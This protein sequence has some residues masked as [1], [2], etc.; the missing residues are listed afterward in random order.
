[1][2]LSRGSSSL[3]LGNRKTDD[4]RRINVSSS[5]PVSTPQSR[6][7]LIGSAR[8]LESS[9]TTDDRF[10]F[11][12]FLKKGITEPTFSPF[13]QFRRIRDIQKSEPEVDSKTGRTKGPGTRFLDALGYEELPAT[14]ARQAFRRTSEQGGKDAVTLRDLPGEIKKGFKEDESF[15]RVF[16]EELAGGKTFDELS[17]GQ[18]I[19]IPTLGLAADI[20]L[21]PT[22]YIPFVGL[23]KAGAKAAKFGVGITRGGVDAA[24]GAERVSKARKA[25][26]VDDILESKL[27]AKDIRGKITPSAPKLDKEG[28]IE[29][30]R[31]GLRQKT[32]EADVIGARAGESLIESKLTPE[33]RTTLE[34]LNEGKQFIDSV[35]DA[36]VR[37]ITENLDL[38][39]YTNARNISRLQPSK[40]DDLLDFGKATIDEVPKTLKADVQSQVKLLAKELDVAEEIAE[41]K[42]VPLAFQR[43]LDAKP[44]A[45][46]KRA[47]AASKG[48]APSIVDGAKLS[49]ANLKEVRKIAGS[50]KGVKKV[51]NTDDDITKKFSQAA[52]DIARKFDIPEDVLERRLKVLLSENTLRQ[53]AKTVDDVAVNV[54]NA[55]NDDQVRLLV[56]SETVDQRIADILA[57]L[58][59]TAKKKGNAVDV[60]PL[61]VARRLFNEPELGAGKKRSF[62]DAVLG[63]GDD[64]VAQ[65]SRVSEPGLLAAGKE[66]DVLKF[67]K[68]IPEEQKAALGGVA[69]IE[70]RVAKGM[71]QSKRLE[72]QLKFFDYVSGTP[73]AQVEKPSAGWVQVKDKAFGPLDKMWVPKPLKHFFDAQS[74]II[75]P[76][77]GK[78]GP[79]IKSIDWLTSRFREGKVVLSPASV[80]R[81]SMSNQLLNFLV[82]PASLLYAPKAIKGTAKGKSA[83]RA[84]RKAREAGDAGA[85]KLANKEFLE[86][87]DDWMQ[88]QRMGGA[89]TSYAR[90]EVMDISNPAKNLDETMKIEQA[91][92]NTMGKIWRDKV[93]EPAASVRAFSEDMGKFQMFLY[94]KSR[95][96]TA[97]QAFNKAQKAT[98]DYGDLTPFEKAYMRRFFAFY[99]FT[100]KSVPLVLSTALNKPQRIN[101]FGDAINEVEGLTENDPNLNEENLPLWARDLVRLPIKDVHGSYR[102]LDLGYI[103]PWGT[104]FESNVNELG[105]PVFG[106][107]N[108]VI[109]E[110]IEQSQNL[111][112][113]TGQPIVG[114]ADAEFPVDA[115]LKRAGHALETFEPRPATIARQK[116][117]PALLGAEKS[118]TGQDLSLTDTLLGDIGGIKLR[119]FEQGKGKRSASFKKSSVLSE[120]NKQIYFAENDGTLTDGQ[121]ERKVQKLEKLKKQVNQGKVDIE[122]LESFL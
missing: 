22:T 80:S 76:T 38:K 27:V 16:R 4:L 84:A 46:I 70:Y 109:S 60:R 50:I 110:F 25:L 87:S 67:R 7:R 53:N 103:F 10:T 3:F 33:A 108:P 74:E 15:G 75:S 78:L 29:T 117:L 31:L 114:P 66:E 12:D 41:R 102:R 113:F 85:M 54:R 23:A 6:A 100:R 32:A 68:W 105:L 47:L 112:T 14:L 52:L 69:P 93:I 43:V 34:N 115:F 64:E 116:G 79:L 61:Y 55:F 11:T 119:S 2:A 39:S 107:G 122:K 104:M 30:A 58:S 19:A 20:L 97:Q 57:T 73:F 81:D 90:A 82:D 45:D 72:E 51:F 13:E 77:S 44:Q 35:A 98:F 86:S 91:S 9:S 92:E 28:T 96:D 65:V 88:F 40:A 26:K 5:R 1:M 63:K 36:N 8:G 83:T 17:P 71:T 21:D 49:D 56:D 95:G 48:E 18:K 24:V 89:N 62:L 118:R 121:R 106:G 37:R 42:L 59:N 120:I 94:R 111:D 101:L 99:T